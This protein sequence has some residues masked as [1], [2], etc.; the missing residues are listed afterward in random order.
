MNWLKNLS[1]N[2]RFFGG[3]GSTTEVIDPRF[4]EQ[5]DLSQQLAGLLGQQLTSGRGLTIPTSPLVAGPSAL[6]QQGFAQAGDF[7]SLLGLGQNIAQQNL[8]Q[9]SPITGQAQQL[10]LQA[11]QDVNRPFDPSIAGQG[12]QAGIQQALSQ[13]GELRRSLLEPF[14]GAGG[15][16]SGAAIRA[17]SRAGENVSLGLSRDFLNKL[18]AGEQNQLNRQLGSIGPAI[19][20][21][22]QPFN[23]S[24]SALSSVG[25]PLSQFL[26]F[27]AQQRDISQQLL[28]EPFQRFGM[29]QGTLQSFLPQILGQQGQTIVNREQGPGISSLFGPLGQLGGAFA[30]TE[31]GAQSLIDFLPFLS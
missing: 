6:Q 25:D 4:T 1:Q 13:T 3:G 22:Q 23:L 29:S 12:L 27:G 19:G 2:R 11:L 10:G 21:A 15:A 9:I 18:F 14:A 28:S 24:R 16:D 17:L 20:L 7:G 5:R 30:G 31:A 26:G 8:A